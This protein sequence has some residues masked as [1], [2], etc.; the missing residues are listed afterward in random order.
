MIDLTGEITSLFIGYGELKIG[1]NSLKLA[2]GGLKQWIR[3]YG[4]SYS[5]VGQFKT[6]ST[7]W[8]AGG[9]YWKKIGSTVLQKWNRNLRQMRLPGNNWRVKDSG[10][11]HWK[12]R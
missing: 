5:H 4:K 3:F 12:K 9:D 7:R 8:G 11:F 2:T 1:L 6:Y 10:H